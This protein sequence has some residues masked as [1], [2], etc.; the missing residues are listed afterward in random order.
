MDT[1]GA[2]KGSRKIQLGQET[3]K[4]TKVNATT[5][6]RGEGT[7]ENGLE[8]VFPNEDVGILGG[9]DRAYIPAKGAMLDMESTPATFEQLGHILQ[10]AIRDVEPVADGSGS[11]QIWQWDFPTTAGHTIQTC[12]IEGGDSNG[13]EEFGYGFV[14]NLT[15]EGVQREAL[16]KAA[17]WIGQTVTPGTYTPDVVI[18]TVEEILASKGRL[19]IDAASGS[20][21]ATTVS[22]TLLDYR[23]GY[24][25]GRQGVDTGE[26]ELHFSFDK[27]QDKSEELLVDVVFEHNATSIAEKAAWEAN[28]PRLLRYKVEGEA[29]TT[30]GT[31]YTNKTLIIDLAGKWEKFEKLGE[32]NGNDIVSGRFRGRY[33]ATVASKGKIILVNEL[34]AM[35]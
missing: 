26:G 12:T 16:M 22:N 7:I 21:G 14:T 10:C 9:T 8:V 23:L 6:W 28:T 25:T 2:P 3:V 15:L 17:S 11:G 20:F 5:V 31:T 34:A 33:N 19:Y 27:Y 35:P 30:A 32:R 18:P 13:E 29:L 1:Y 24:V 4:G